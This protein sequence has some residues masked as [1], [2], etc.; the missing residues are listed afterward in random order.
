MSHWLDRVFDR[1]GS[2]RVEL[3]WTLIGL[4]LSP[5]RIARL[6]TGHLDTDK[7][8]RVVRHRLVGI[9]RSCR[10]RLLLLVG[11]L[12]TQ[13]HRTIHTQLRLRLRE[14]VS[15]LVNLLIH[16][17]LLQDG[18]AQVAQVRIDLE[19]QFVRV[20]HQVEHEPLGRAAIVR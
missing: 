19:V 17:F 11:E 5:R 20:V 13:G 1:G 3:R 6:L 4:V 15:K 16:V 2:R 8:I 10:F 9:Q 7:I 14:L 12:L 18:S